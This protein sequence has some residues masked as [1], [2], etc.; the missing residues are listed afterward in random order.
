MAFSVHVNIERC[1]GCGNCVAA[2]PVNALE[3]YTFEPVTREKIYTV[4]DGKSI[5]LDFKSELCA[6]CG[7][8]IDACPYNVISLSGRGEFP[9][10]RAVS[11]V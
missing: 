11:P 2:C 5:S 3:I 7:V 6:G 8:C 1:T 10:E 9:S 4:R